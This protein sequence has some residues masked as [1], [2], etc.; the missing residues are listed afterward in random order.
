MNLNKVK[1]D[2]SDNLSIRNL[3]NNTSNTDELVD[4]CLQLSFDRLRPQLVSI[5]L[6]NKKGFF[7]KISCKGIDLNGKHIDNKWFSEERHAIGS[8]F[9]GKVAIC[10]PGDFY[11]E[12]QYIEKLDLEKIDDRCRQKYTEKLGHL[13]CAMAVPLNGEHRTYGV[14]EVINKLDAQNKLSRTAFSNRDYFWLSIIGNHLATAISFRKKR[15]EFDLLSY[16]SHELIEPFSDNYEPSKVYKNIVDT[17]VSSLSNYKACILRVANNNRILEIV[18][19]SGDDIDWDSFKDVP[20]ETEDVTPTKVFNSKNIVQIEN[21][22]KCTEEFIN[23]LWIKKN[24]L[25][26]YYCAP[27]F[28]NDESLGTLSLFAGYKCKN[29]KTDTD[30]IANL[31]KLIGAHIKIG[32]T[33]EEL[34]RKKRY[35]RT[36]LDKELNTSLSVAFNQSISENY[37]KQKN[38]FIKIQTELYHAKD[39]NSGRLRIINE[40]IE[41]LGRRI[42]ELQHQ[43]EDTDL[44]SV[45]LNYLLQDIVQYFKI[46]V[47]ERK[48][49]NIFFHSK[50]DYKIPTILANVIAL[51][52]VFRNI[53]QNSIKFILKNYKGIGNITIQSSQVVIDGIEYIQIKV[54]D[55]GIGIPEENLTRIFERKFSTDEENGTGFGLYFV[56]SVISQ[57]YGGHVLAESV[58]GEWTTI[59]VQIPLN[60]N[61]I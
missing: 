34:Q 11:G 52:K 23:D 13:K 27:L 38:E 29:Y 51:R 61:R 4:K 21:L 33:L 7:E 22:Q 2:I 47:K 16:I 26:S 55:D 54:T 5:F 19:K 35:I 3:L 48:R 8:S 58:Q 25:I 20:I 14:L 1:R 39:D 24:N 40:Q 59:F 45:N 10:K 43:V 28:V 57:N 15:K 56:D 6:F 9:T 46:E 18:A 49:N 53:I 37:H 44:S 32:Q 36:E 17:L 30:F 42:E 50:L 41:Y 31:C 60:R 12:A